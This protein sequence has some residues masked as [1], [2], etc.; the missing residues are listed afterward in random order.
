MIKIITDS[1]ADL[2]VKYIEQYD[3]E[4]I[5]IIVTLDGKNYREK[6]DISSEE[7][8]KRMFTSNELPKTSQPSPATF[9]ESFSKFGQNT[10][11]LCL[12]V[13]SG[14]SG[15]YQSACIGKDLSNSSNVTVFDT[16][17]ASLGHGLQVIRAA[18]LAK[19]GLTVEEIVANLTEYRKNMNILVILNTLENIV[20]GGRLSK[21][22]GS[23]AK[24]LN[25]K[26][27]LERVEGGKVE[28]LEKVRGMKRLQNRVLEL[29]HERGKDLSDVTIGI[30]HS[31]NFDEVE[32]LKQNLFQRFNPKE[33]IVNYMGAAI[34]T[35]AGK[36]G[37]IIAF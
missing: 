12:T 8:L 21:F 30:S 18:E 25:I 1:S 13:S 33:I 2:P 27:I 32:T 6:I 9:V 37:M 14:L 23:L 31:G 5:P 17:A 11:I 34:G 24:I 22:E 19:Q 16:L 35:Y 3:I 4:V 29:I 10:D 36:D 15:T 7:F 26:V 20:K 28:V